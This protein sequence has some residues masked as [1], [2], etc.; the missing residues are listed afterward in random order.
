[1]VRASALHAEGRRFDS[2]NLHISVVVGGREFDSLT[3]GEP[4]CGCLFG[5]AYPLWSYSGEY[6]Y[7][8]FRF[9][10][11]VVKCFSRV[12]HKAP[13]LEFWILSSNI[14]FISLDS[15]TE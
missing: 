10:A 2:A 9:M 14:R 11:G 5:G 8:L 13:G 1:M 4:A 3:R 6:V 12:S 15:S 7:L